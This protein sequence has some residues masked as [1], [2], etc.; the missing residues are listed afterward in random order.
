[1]LARSFLSAEQLGLEEAEHTALIKVLHM[2]ERGEI[3]YYDAGDT[4][5]G[6]YLRTK[7]I[8]FNMQAF[9][10]KAGCGTIHCMAGWAEIVGRLDPYQLAI[11]RLGN[12][13]TANQLYELFE[14][15]NHDVPT[16]TPAQAAHALSNY[17]TTGEPRWAEALA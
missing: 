5:D 1:M 9:Y 4:A 17:L 13:T 10:A 2:L 11:K 7:P 15:P 8:G 16:I 12:N 14:A 6:K 3:A